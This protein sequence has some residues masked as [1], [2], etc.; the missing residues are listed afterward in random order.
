MSSGN[1]LP[2]VR[3]SFWARTID[4]AV[5]AEKKQRGDRAEA[6]LRDELFVEAMDRIHG[7]YMDHWKNSEAFDFETR[8][9]AYVAV[10]LLTDLQNQLISYVR[11]GQVA[12]GVI[13][14][15]LRR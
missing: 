12:R 4:P 8:E 2:Y 10:M 11:D 13:E 15:S 6:L 1:T 5:E 3:P 9:R 14:K 7:T